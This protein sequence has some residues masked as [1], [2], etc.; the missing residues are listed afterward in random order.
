MLP[1]EAGEVRMSEGRQDPSYH[2]QNSW[3]S[4][5]RA[6]VMLVGFAWIPFLLIV[7][8]LNETNH[9]RDFA[10]VMI[11]ILFMLFMLAAPTLLCAA[12]LPTHKARLLGSPL[13]LIAWSIFLFARDPSSHV[14]MPSPMSMLPWGLTCLAILVA[15]PELP[16]VSWLYRR[17]FGLILR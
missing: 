17:F 10:F 13:V 8:M 14:N 6:A 9:G 12:L 11:G 4:K 5:V 3:V 1:I 7:G 16:F 2:P 15:L